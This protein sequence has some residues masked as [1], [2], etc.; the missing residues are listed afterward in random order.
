MRRGLVPTVLGARRSRLQPVWHSE[1]GAPRISATRVVFE[2]EDSEQMDGDPPAEPCHEDVSVDS[3]F[4]HDLAKQGSESMVEKGLLTPGQT[5]KFGVSVYPRETR[6]TRAT[7]STGANADPSAAAKDERDDRAEPRMQF[8]EVVELLVLHEK[9]IEQLA[10]HAR[11]AGRNARAGDVRV[12]VP[13]TVVDEVVA[14][15][16]AAGEFEVGGMM[17][18]HLRR[19]PGS[20]EIYVEVTAQVP[21]LHTD[22]TKASLTFTPE[23]WA[24][25]NDA[26]ALRGAGEYCV[27]WWHSHPNFSDNACAKCPEERRRLCPLSRPFFSPSDIH[28]HRTLFSRA[29]HTALLVSDFGRAELDVSFFGWRDGAVVSRGFEVFASN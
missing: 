2:P 10:R 5:Y 1:H 25:A 18:G 23:S 27:S 19:S 6:T 9:P 28:M 29:Y 15:A 16:R 22:A 24:A 4:F 21:A 14:A 17:L 7:S 3:A 20:P 13:R 8:E 12:F 11:P 26:I